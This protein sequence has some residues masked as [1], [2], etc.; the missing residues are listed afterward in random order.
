V[1]EGG[2]PEVWSATENVVWKVGVPGR[3]WSSPIVGDGRIFLTSV[4]NEGEEEEPKKGLYLGGERNKPESPHRFTVLCLEVDSGKVLWERVA[5]RGAPEN[6]R[7][8]KNSYASETPLTDGKRLYAYFGEAGLFAYDLEGRPLW[9]RKWGS[10]KTR[11]GWG[12]AS[13]PA[14]HQDRIYVVNDNEEKSFLAAVDSRTGDELWRRERDEKSNWSTPFIWENGMRTELVTTGSGKVRSYDLE[15]KPLWELSGMSSITIPTPV[16]GAGL[17]FVSSGFVM[18]QVRPIYAVRPGASGDL[19]LPADAST[20][21]SVAWCQKKA[22]SYHPSPL[23]YGD[24]LYVL[25]DRGFLSCHDARTGK[26][27]YPRERLSPEAQAFTA[28]PWAYGGKVFCLSEDGDAFVVEAGDK[29]KVVG[30]NSLGEMC[31]AT[32]AM[33]GGSLFVRTI[34]HLY[35]IQGGK[36]KP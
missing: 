16:A 12:T 5:H 20:S 31:M 19:T 2:L 7:H 32:P 11:Y 27:I 22:A 28:S 24:R 30:K 13:S 3:G 4:V 34:S 21:G 10:F 23:F 29:P 18:D 15:G 33:A 36:G 14:M 8:L 26:E 1:G 17:L 6:S 9:S 25:L 35:R